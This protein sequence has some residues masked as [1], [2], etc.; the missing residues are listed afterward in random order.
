MISSL[1]NR[2][3]HWVLLCLLKQFPKFNL[4]KLPQKKTKKDLYSTSFI[5]WVSKELYD[6][7]LDRKLG[8]FL[9]FK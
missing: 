5:K 1:T 8:F 7:A 9:K 4:S 2:K 6:I 3:L